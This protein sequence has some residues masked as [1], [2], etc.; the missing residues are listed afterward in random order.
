LA[1]G[2]TLKNQV[3]FNRIEK[4]VRFDIFGGWNFKHNFEVDI[5]LGASLVKRE[6]FNI[7]TD[8]QYSFNKEKRLTNI[9][10]FLEVGR[11]VTFRPFIAV[12]KIKYLNPGEPVENKLS[13]GFALF[14]WF[15]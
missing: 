13:F 7:S 3:D 4:K 11:D 14:S 8:L 5:K 12:E 1:A 2:I 10:L 9:R 15:D 6:F